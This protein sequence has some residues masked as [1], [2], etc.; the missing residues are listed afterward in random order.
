MTASTGTGD[1]TLGLNL[2]SVGSIKDLA[3]NALTG[4]PFTG[5]VYTI[6][7]TLPAVTLTSI[8]G[9]GR[10][11]PYESTADVTSIGGGCSTVDGKRQLGRDRIADGVGS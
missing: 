10:T 6:D 4:L 8:N 2:T 5:Q 9:V 3:N 1:G 7:K 11:F